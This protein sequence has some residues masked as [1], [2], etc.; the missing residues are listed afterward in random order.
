MSRLKALLI[1]FSFVGSVYSEESID[2]VREFWNRQP[3]NI[4][5]SKQVF[6]TKEYF[7][8]VESRKYF[9]E[10]H[11]PAFAEFDKWKDKEVLEIGCGIGTDSVNFARAGAK[12]TVIEL[13]EQSLEIAKKRFALYGLDANFIQCNA[14]NM[15]QYLGNKTFDLV[16]S[17]G[18]I[19]HTPHPE[20]IFNEIEKVLKPDG[21]LRVM[22]YSKY[23]TKNFM[24]VLGLSQ[25]EAQY[26]CPIANTYSES[27]II[28]LLSAFEVYSCVKDHIFPYKIPEYKKFIYEKRFPW[29]IMPEGMFRFFEKNFG[30]HTL[31]KAK[32]KNPETKSV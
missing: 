27:E 10:P 32:K 19:H 14:E 5:H 16:Y 28:K 15:T 8:Q 3:C 26:G 22:L 23:S 6:G 11:I 13:S 18:V 25:P 17:F 4:N 31:I 7:D 30:W 12:L 29:N 1:V 24:I 2:T 9:V 20:L 21:E